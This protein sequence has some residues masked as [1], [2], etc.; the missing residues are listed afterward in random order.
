MQKWHDI[1]CLFLELSHWPSEF[2]RNIYVKYGKMLYY[3]ISWAIA[4]MMKGVIWH[5]WS[6]C[7]HI[8]EIIICSRDFIP[9]FLH[10]SVRWLSFEWTISITNIY[11]YSSMQ[12]TC[13]LWKNTRLPIRR[14]YIGLWMGE[15]N[16]ASVSFAS[17][18]HF[19]LRQSNIP[20]RLSLSLMS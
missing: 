12:Q 8:T 16:Q 6:S 15:N 1:V 10:C 5:F 17:V 7:W 13:M 3:F 11:W 18:R 9:W 14:R 20:P 19:I 4:N 2:N